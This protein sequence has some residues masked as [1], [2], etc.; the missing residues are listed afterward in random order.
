M[1]GFMYRGHMLIF[2]ISAMAEFLPQWNF[3]M[4]TVGYQQEAS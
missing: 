2:Y 1:Q 4:F 3:C